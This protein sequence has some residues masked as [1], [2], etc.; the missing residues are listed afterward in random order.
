MPLACFKAYDIRGK[1]GEELTPEIAYL[2][3]R[4]YC[5]LYQP[6]KVVTGRDVRSSSA[7]LQRAIKQGFA[8]SGMD[9]VD[10]GVCGSEE[11]YYATIHGDFSG[12][13]MVTGSHNPLNYNGIKIVREKAAPISMD[14][15][16]KEIS[17][18]VEKHLG[19]EKQPVHKMGTFSDW[20]SKEHYITHLNNYFNDGLKPL[21][22]LVNAGNG[23]AGRIIDMLEAYVPFEF[24]KINHTPNPTFPNGVPN[25]M[26]PKNRKQTVDAVKENHAD[27]GIAWDGDFDRCFLFDEK[28][29]YISAY[30]LLGVLS[31][32]FLKQA[33]GGRVICDPRLNWATLE[34]IE[35]LGGEAIISKAGHS[36]IK[37]KMKEKDA[38][39]GG[40][41]SGHFFF[42][43]F[44]YCDSGM[45]PWIIVAS[46]MCA[47][48]KKLSEIIGTR[49]EQFPSCDEMN[50]PLSTSADV[51]IEKVEKHYT[52]QAKNISHLDG[53]SVEFNDW[54]FNLRA[55][56]TEPLV[57]L[58]VES[59]NN[60]SLM[61]EKLQEVLQVIQ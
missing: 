32:F 34:S 12:G 27:M 24:I 37:E 42:K 9:V 44:G 23:P 7:Q 18:Y 60:V 39:F 61:E 56:N 21:K 16:L 33:D 43:S 48:G 57:R 40:E 31:E 59:R 14:S 54:R 35:K 46:H 19:K 52:P 53:L 47:T 1:L 8:E 28:G 26:L 22:I 3:A 30:Y 15:G 25:P 6:K 11:M 10:I 55:S 17:D 58:N 50:L 4:G 5:E 38:V 13:M 41:V 51:I 2:T 45:I 20:T 29:N 49:Y 36:F